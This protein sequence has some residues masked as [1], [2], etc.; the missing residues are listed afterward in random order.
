MAGAGCTIKNKG[1]AHE[2]QPPQVFFAPVPLEN[3]LFTAPSLLFWYATDPDGYIVQFEYSIQ[4]DSLIRATKRDSAG[5]PI[6]SPLDFIQKHPTSSGDTIWKWLVVSNLNVNG[7]TAVVAL[8]SDTFKVFRSVVFIRARDDQG[9]YTPDSLLRWRSFRRQNRPPNS[10]ISS[11]NGFGGSPVSEVFFTLDRRTFS[12]SSDRRTGHNGVTIK[13][14]GSDSLDYPRA[15]PKFD[16]FWELFG[17]FTDVFSGRADSTRL[18]ASSEHP[19]HYNPSF[20]APRYA[21]ADSVTLYGL[22]GVDMPDNYKIGAYF[23]RVRS[24]DDAGVS[25]PTPASLRFQVI[26]PRFDRKILLVWKRPRTSSGPTGEPN[27]ANDSASQSYY[28]DLIR[29]AGYDGS[30]FDAVYDAKTFVADIAIP[31]SLLARYQFVIYHKEQLIRTQD[32]A[33]SGSLVKYMNGGGSVWG[34]GR[35]DLLDL[36]GPGSGI[37]DRLSLVS[38]N[39]FDPSIGV[40]FFYFGIDA[41]V[42]DHHVNEVIAEERTHVSNEQFVGADTLLNSQTDPRAKVPGLPTLDVD[43]LVTKAYIRSR[44]R[45]RPDSLLYPDSLYRRMPGVNT[46]QRAVR[47]QP[48]YLY[49]SAFSDTSKLNG[50]VV[51]VRSDRGS[52]KTAQFGFSLYGIQKCQAVFL[53][54]K[55]LEW[56]IGPPSSGLPATCP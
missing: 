3:T 54:R 47:S 48:L 33:L 24:R 22:R 26:H 53:T 9:A 32:F 8:P 55:M 40:A 49:R 23:F 1:T 14:F 19:D 41:M 36:D 27:R 16:Y 28:I 10:Y 12:D 4:S 20:T 35:D 52:F 2:N 51:A 13:W 18:W 31:D 50:Q 43:T 6:G 45:I 42:S 29:R 56:F 37:D 38:Y 34:L 7:Q 15:Q 46:F 17:P 39:D 21:P 44:F 25:D 30:D 11:V 5:I